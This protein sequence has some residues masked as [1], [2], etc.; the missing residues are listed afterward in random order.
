V[1]VSAESTCQNCHL[2]CHGQLWLTA[3]YIHSEVGWYWKLLSYHPCCHMLVLSPLLSPEI[4]T[5]YPCTALAEY[6]CE[7][8]TLKTDGKLEIQ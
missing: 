8:I 6:E 2:C 4:R 5:R 7:G 3:S 1:Q